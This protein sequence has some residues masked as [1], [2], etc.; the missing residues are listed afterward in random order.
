MLLAG[1]LLLPSGRADEAELVSAERPAE[2]MIYQYPDTDLLLRIDVREAEFSV[3][4]AGPEGALLKISSLPGRRIG[5]IYQYIDATPRSRQL[6]IEVTPARPLLR[7]AIGLEVLQFSPD[8][9][10]NRNLAKAY[11]MLSLGTESPASADAS[12]WASKA[13]SLRN[14]AA[15]FSGMGREEMRLWSEYLAAHVVLFR[16]DDPLMAS[17]LVEAVH[18][19]AVRA[20]FGQV[21]LAARIL[22]AEAAMRLAAGSNERSAPGRYEKAHELLGQVATLAGGQG[23]ALEHGRAMYQDGRMY[24]LQGEPERA[25]ERYQAALEIVDGA[26]DAELLNEIRATAASIYESTGRTTGAIAI[27]ADIAD[28]LSGVPQENVDLDLAAQLFEKGR[29][30]NITYRY[31][32][33]LVELTRALEL[34]RANA[35][36]RLWGPTGLELAWSYYSMGETGAALELLE[37]SL[38]PALG[39]VNTAAL[40]RAWSS[41]G[42]IHRGQRQ[43]AQAAQARARLAEHIG[44]GAGRAA[45]LLDIALDAWFEG[46]QSGGRAPELLQRALRAAEEEGDSASRH[47]ATLYLCQLQPERGQQSACRGAATAAYRGLR[48]SGVP[49]LAADGAFAWSR[50]LRRWGETSAAAESM[51]RLIDGL[52]WYQRA[53]PGVL[54]AWY[55]ENRDLI[56]REYLAVMQAA[57]PEAAVGKTMLLAMEQVRT[58][59]AAD[60]FTPRDRPL[61]A[62][63]EESL[64][65]LLARREGS[66]PND[67]ERLAAEATRRLGEA[68]QS[69][70]SLALAFPA[71]NLEN[72]LA[73]LGRSEAVLSYYFDGGRAQALVARRGG[74]EAIE[75]PSTGRIAERLQS[76]RAAWTGGT[77]GETITRHLD[78]LGEVLLEPLEGMLP[79]KVYLLPVGPLRGLPFDAL[80]VQRDYFAQ[81]H[82]LVNLA[83]LASIERRAP[84]MP[85][86]FSERVFLAGNPQDSGDPFSLEFRASPEITAVTD[87]FVGAGLHIVQGVALKRDEFDDER[88]ARASLVHLALAGT[89][90]LSF[91]ERSRLLLAPVAAAHADSRSFLAPRDVRD[92]ELSADLV[93][94]SGTAVVGAGNARADGPLAFVADFLHVGAAAVLVS[95]RPAGERVNAGF[96]ADLYRQLKSDPDIESAVAGVKRSRIEGDTGTNLQSWAGFQLFIR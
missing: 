96:A 77:A 87:E 78:N 45:L 54:G 61:S 25:L 34:Q 15:I 85:S 29:L 17:E 2:Y 94:L 93:V 79:G 8:D 71:E 60:S 36:A 1:L 9:R 89:L 7:S 47:R 80:R 56:A 82:A 92:F 13:Y 39:Q 44:N 58:L 14:A 32:E 86:D 73:G 10:N 76:F 48:D 26:G 95:Y 52:Y 12:T 6:T 70:G 50:L 24:E 88:L 42:N 84:A 20:G 4:T 11:K 68:R 51:Q 37:E 3:R 69:A 55:A 72:L 38:P 19:D 16:L 27:R 18:R 75:L 57:A 5:P 28:D 31:R 67:E 30:L 23:F 63:D 65:D 41:L 21:E 49:R 40:I 62:A 53:L 43:F 46:G 22:E 74:I 83:S 35:E 59:E 91:P 64:R 66:I 90:D 33:A 81:R